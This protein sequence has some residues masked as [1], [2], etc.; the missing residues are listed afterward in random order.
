MKKKHH[1]IQ[2]RLIVCSIAEAV[3]C[4]AQVDEG[5]NEGAQCIQSRLRVIAH[6][7]QPT[8]ATNRGKDKNGSRLAITRSRNQLQ[9]RA[10]HRAAIFAQHFDGICVLCR[11]FCGKCFQFILI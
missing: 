11:V 10:K 9:S 3:N 8:S 4:T 6:E 2:C 5:E 1:Y 7:S